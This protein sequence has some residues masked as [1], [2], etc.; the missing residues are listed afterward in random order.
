MALPLLEFAPMS[1]QTG[2]QSQQSLSNISCQIFTFKEGLLSAIAHDLRLVVERCSIDLS[3]EG[4]GGAQ[5]GGADGTAGGVVTAI[6]ATFDPRSLRVVCAQRDGQDQL[7]ALS[8]DQRAEI[9]RHIQH[10]ILHTD[11]YPEVRFVS[12][13][14]TPRAG[15]YEVLGELSLHGQRRAIVASVAKQAERW[16]CEVRL[17][18]PDFGIKPFSAALGTLRVRAALL[19]TVAVPVR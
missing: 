18:Q 10:D 11:R 14:V 15:A 17:N 19:V 16:L 4:S 9:D 2:A 3:V 6:A 7:S 12:T 13:K 8:V 1:D 5:G